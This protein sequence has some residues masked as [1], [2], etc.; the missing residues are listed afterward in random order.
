[1]TWVQLFGKCY[2]M[3]IVQICANFVAFQRKREG[4][5]VDTPPGGYTA[6]IVLDYLSY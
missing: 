5:A 1:M 3:E 2:I 6:I 4:D